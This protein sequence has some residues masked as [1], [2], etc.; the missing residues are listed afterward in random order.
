MREEEG[1]DRNFLRN[2]Q[3]LELRALVVMSWEIRQDIII[4]GARDTE[5]IVTKFYRW[6]LY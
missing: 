1:K 2:I 6:I 3:Y 5:N 4:E